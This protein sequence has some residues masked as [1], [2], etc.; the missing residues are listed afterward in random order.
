MHAIITTIFGL[1]CFL[2]ALMPF[3]LMAADA[4]AKCQVE[5]SYATCVTALW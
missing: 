1:L 3:W 2:L 5:H 4:M